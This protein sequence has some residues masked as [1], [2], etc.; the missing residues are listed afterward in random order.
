MQT[1]DRPGASQGVPVAIR[2][3]EQ[4]LAKTKR[5][6][7][8]L[9]D[10][11]LMPVAGKSRGEMISRG[12]PENTAALANLISTRTTKRDTFAISTFESFRV[13]DPVRDAISSPEAHS[14]QE[15]L[16]TARESRVDRFA[17]NC[18]RGCRC[19]HCGTTVRHSAS[20]C[21]RSDCL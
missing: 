4:A 7:Q 1:E 21:A 13:F 2:V 18:F 14:A 17:S 8:M 12:T 3:R 11:D 16:D 19:D 5:P 9:A 10:A 6:Y 20:T 15:L